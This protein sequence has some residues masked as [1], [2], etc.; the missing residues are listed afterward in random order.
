MADY[1]SSKASSS[2]VQPQEG[3]IRCAHLLVKHKGSRR[4]VSWRQAEI[5]RTKEEA[6]AI[7]AGFEMEI[8]EKGVSLGNLARKESDCSSARM[9]GDL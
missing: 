9:G 2:T 5:T 1:H 7:I 6:R 3:K 8:K 4:P